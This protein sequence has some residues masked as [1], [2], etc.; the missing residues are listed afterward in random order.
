MREGVLRAVRVAVTIPCTVKKRFKLF[1][2]RES[3]V[4]DLPAGE[5]KTANL[6]YSVLG[7]GIPLGER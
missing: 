1:L 7:S 4:S 6:F 2:A 5:G 3:F